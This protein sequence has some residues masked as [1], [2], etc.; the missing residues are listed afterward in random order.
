MSIMNYRGMEITFAEGKKLRF[1]FP[2][3]ATEENMAQRME[4]ALKQPSLSISA[5]GTLYIIPTSAIKTITVTPTPKK[6]ARTVIRGA[7]L[8]E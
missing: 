6:L 7:S 8:Q 1:K 2:I 3:Q 4:E 5:D